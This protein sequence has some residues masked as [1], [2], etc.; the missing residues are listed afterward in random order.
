MRLLAAALLLYWTA[1]M[2]ALPQG[3]PAGNAAG[4]GAPAVNFE[5][6]RQTKVVTAI[7]ITERI[8][9]DGRLEEPA[10]SLAIPA[11][12]FWQRVPVNG[13]P[14][15]EQSEVRFLYDDDN[16]YVGYS[17]L[18]SD[19]SRMGTSE[20]KEDFNFVTNEAIAVT[21]DSLHDGRS[22]F[23]FITNPSGA[24]RDTQISNDST[25]NAD[26][27]GVWDVKVSVNESGWVAEYVI[28]FKTLRFS[29][30]PTQEWGVNMTRRLVRLNEE[31]NWSP[32][33]IRYAVRVSLAGTLQGIENIRQGLNFKVKPFVTGGVTQ[34][35]T[36][37]GMQTLQSLTRLK[38]YDTGVDTKYSLTSQLTLDTTWR[39][40]FAQVEV[41][42]QQVNLTRFNLFFPEKRDFFLENSGTFGF[43]PGGNLVPFF[44][45]RIGLS[46]QGT[47]IPIQGGARVS[48]KVSAYDVGF[49][50]MK[51]DSLGEAG[52]VGYAPSNNYLVGRVK[53]NLL[54]NS[55]V[56]ALVTSRDS[57]TAGDYNR[58]YGADA[59][60][61][62][63]QRLEFD[64]YLLQSGT[65]GRSGASQARRFQSAWRDDEFGFGGEYN[66]V[67]S[68]FNPEVGF[69]RRGDSEHYSGDAS[70]RPQF[71]NSRTLQNLSF[72]MNLDYYG[73]AGSGKVETRT[74]DASFGISFKNGRSLTFT[75]A[76][77]FD[78]LLTPFRIRPTI[79]IP[80]G[81]YEYTGYSARFGTNQSLRLSGN[82]SFE[83]GGFWNGRHESFSGGVTLK[84][85]KHLTAD[86]TYNRNHVRLPID[87]FTTNLLGA[88]ILYGFTPRAFLNAFIQYNADTNQVS[89]NIRFNLTHR[90]LSDIYLV[91]NDRRDT[92]NGDLLERAFI[93]KVT[94]LFSF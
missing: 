38:D 88:R 89:S 25:N 13:V 64:S 94:N 60:F 69:V 5:A 2:T 32:H 36:P 37:A 3:S 49:L 20:L 22:G 90:P 23:A 7:R 51:T 14:A 19:P 33:P 67:Q 46:A 93:V 73:G 12:D 26:W 75:A 68:D 6:V 35:R 31:S 80:A 72:T 77:T 71:R 30:S 91:Y 54:S 79:S 39:T 78:R 92:S 45:R 48:G 16:L 17:A 9:L 34:V 1:V 58:V 82:G 28:P 53:R 56:G 44:S 43:G 59:H 81:D 24:K 61:Q 55:W 70:W 10:W 47:P 18:D 27:D 42:Q 21:I 29:N 41:D 57:S 63:F 4:V 50:A 62:F 76:R 11:K 74:Q 65:P 84:P 83:W 87:S 85:N 52:T 66:L 15:T 86:V 8:S 40:D